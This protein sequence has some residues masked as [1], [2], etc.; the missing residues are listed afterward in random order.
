MWANLCLFQTYYC[1][2]Y[3]HVNLLLFPVDC[4]LVANWNLIRLAPSWLAPTQL[5]SNSRPNF[6]IFVCS[7]NSRECVVLFVIGTWPN[8]VRKVSELILINV[9]M[10][11]LISLNLF[12]KVYVWPLRH[13]VQCTYLKRY[14]RRIFFSDTLPSTDTFMMASSGNW[15]RDGK[16][17]RRCRHVCAIFL[18]WC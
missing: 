18:S 12:S 8:S 15:H 2:I 5:P 1:W 14:E 3:T 11:Y 16:S 17:G 9:W 10:L 4:E 7:H 13:F 6:P